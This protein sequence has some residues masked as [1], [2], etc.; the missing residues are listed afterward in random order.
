[1]VYITPSIN[2]LIFTTKA[3]YMP[4]NLILTK[5][6]L[7]PMNFLVFMNAFILYIVKVIFNTLLSNHESKYY[8][9]T[10]NV[11]SMFK[12]YSIFSKMI[13]KES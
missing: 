2:T 5:N 4:Q 13:N 8:F 11:M 6:N 9:H 7:T 1:M 3:L 12:Y 10:I